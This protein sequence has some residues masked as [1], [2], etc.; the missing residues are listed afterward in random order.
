M[1]RFILMITIV[2]LASTAYAGEIQIQVNTHNSALARWTAEDFANARP[3]PM[4]TI[5]DAH[6]AMPGAARET[7][8][9]DLMKERFGSEAEEP[10][11]TGDQRYA[12]HRTLFDYQSKRRSD[13]REGTGAEAPDAALKNYGH[14]RLHYTSS[15][16]IPSSAAEHFPYSAIGK[17]FFSDSEGHNHWCTASVI[18]RRLIITAAHC[19]H[20][21]PRYGWWQDW[22]FVPAYNYGEAPF[23]AWEYSTAFVSTEWSDGEIWAEDWGLLELQ[24]QEGT[25]ISEVTGKLGFITGRLG[26]N[27]L[28][29]VGYPGGYDEGGEMHQVTSGD[30]E[31]WLDG[32]MYA[33]GNDMDGGSSGSP[34]VQ[35]FNRKSPGQGG[36][37]NRAR[38]AVTGVASVGSM[39]HRNQA[40]WTLNRDFKVLRQEACHHQAGNC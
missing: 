25:K 29:M 19:L 6:K 15:R 31:P 11:L 34:W 22:V 36:G 16:L 39:L 23:G 40:A 4:P 12:L 8:P 33:Y 21:G 14:S 32:R 27:H 1:K 20:R 3:F 37:L 9:G 30:S 24:D 2:C 28:T 38:L 10:T 18:A 13:P 17:L 26:P 35:N 7:P 5:E